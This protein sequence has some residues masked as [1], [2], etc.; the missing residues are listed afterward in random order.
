MN[1]K[2]SNMS[3]NKPVIVIHSNDPAAVVRCTGYMIL[4]ELRHAQ[5]WGAAGISVHCQEP[6]I[7]GCITS[8][9]EARQLMAL[10]E[11]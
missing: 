8:E 10:F 1:H 4:A 7:S 2:P 6:F 11:G 3:I 5:T 9:R